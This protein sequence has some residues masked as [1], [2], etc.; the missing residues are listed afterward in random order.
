MSS[1]K[2]RA[3]YELA[4]RFLNEDDLGRA[5]MHARNSLWACENEKGPALDAF[6][7]QEA[8][9]R[10]HH[11]DEDRD[12]TRRALKLM[13]GHFDRLANDDQKRYQSIL[14]SALALL[15]S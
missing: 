4:M 2:S 11:A 9:A 6:F 13:K 7:A 15:E 3:E 5:L 1:N 12:S 14:D 10:I 8:F